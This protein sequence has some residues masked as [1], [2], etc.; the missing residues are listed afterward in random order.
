M[1]MTALDTD[2]RTDA[3]CLNTDVE[4]FY[5]TSPT[6]I[7][8]VPAKTV[9]WPCP[10]R[11]DCLNYALAERDGHGIFGGLTWQERQQ[12]AD[13]ARYDPDLAQAVAD[14]LADPGRFGHRTPQSEQT[15]CRRYQQGDTT[16][17]IACDYDISSVT[18]VK[19]LRDNNIPL[20]PHGGTATAGVCF[21]G[22]RIEGANAMRNG[23]APDGVQRYACRRCYLARRNRR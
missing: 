21:R 15:I 20:R 11:R 12:V 7:A 22:H 16:A 3:A 13:A 6:P 5:P 10:V 2:W 17:A 9:C 18:V 1:G 19:I 23:R 14:E 8:A 4:T